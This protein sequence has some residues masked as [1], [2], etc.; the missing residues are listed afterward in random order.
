MII[1]FHLE[2][3]AYYDDMLIRL[4]NYAVSDEEGYKRIDDSH[5]V[6]KMPQQAVVFLKDTD[7]SKDKLYIKLILPDEQEIEYSVHAVRSLG[8]TP[9]ELIANDMEILLPFQILRLYGSVKKYSSFSEEQKNEFL[10][11]FAQMCK[12]IAETLHKLKKD[13]NVTTDEYYAMVEI[14]HDLEEYI[15]GMVDND[16]KAKGADSMINDEFLFWSERMKAEKDAETTKLLKEKDA[17]TAKLLKEK[18]DQ[19]ARILKEKEDEKNRYFAEKMIMNG[20]SAEKI[21]E[22]TGLHLSVLKSM[23]QSLG[24]ALML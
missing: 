22:Y 1:G 13:K 23:A 9:Q 5:A 15:Y 19:T 7:K 17:E 20:E 11:K 21:E 24:K 3:Q 18:D 4:F 2:A 16:I 6:F 14:I 8:Y 12:D 10:E